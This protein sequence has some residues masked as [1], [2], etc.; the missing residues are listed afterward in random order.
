MAIIKE[1][2]LCAAVWFKDGKKYKH[3]PLNIKSGFIIC[4]QRHHNCFMTFSILRDKTIKQFKYG[5]CI[6]GFLTSYN[7]FV[8]RK[9]GGVIAY[10]ARQILKPTEYLFSEDLY[11]NY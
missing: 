6:Q 3:Q 11:S 8:N 1:T 5:D 2:I 10:D 9:E 4:G 7:N